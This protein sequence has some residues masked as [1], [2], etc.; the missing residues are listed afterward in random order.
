MAR[1]CSTRRAERCCTSCGSSGWLPYALGPNDVLNQMSV[2]AATRATL[3][4]D[5]QA[6][7]IAAQDSSS[8]ALTK[9]GYLPYGKSASAGPFGFT[10]QRVD[11]ETGGFYYYR[12]RHYSPAWGRFLQV[13]PIGYSGGTH[14]YAYVGNDPL[15][16]IDSNGLIIESVG[17][18]Y[19]TFA[20]GSAAEQNATADYFSQ[21]PYALAAVVA[22]PLV[23][24][25]VGAVAEPLI[26]GGGAATVTQLA[27]ATALDAQAAGA[28]RGVAAALRVGDTV[29]TDVSSGA[30]RQIGTTPTAVNPT[31]QTLINSFTENSAFAGS[32]AEVGCVSQALNAGINPSGG[33][34]ATAAI[35]GAGS[36]AQGTSVAPCITCFQIHRI[37]GIRFI[38]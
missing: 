37:F 23:A 11:V 9:V 20:Q 12:A 1:W 3:L 5:I 34:I 35:R 29:F 22:S 36:A 21:H 38:Q 28:T 15:N 10:G 31:I 32:C 6:S 25:G 19:S 14:L 7:I 27:G 17:Q 33:T 8:G 30:A 2:A 16:E 13:D 4:P 18:S 26:A 24:T